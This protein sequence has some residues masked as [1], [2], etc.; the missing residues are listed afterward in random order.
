METIADRLRKIQGEIAVAAERCG[1]QAKDVTLIA[2]SKTHPAEAIREAWDEG[3]RIFGESR[4]QEALAK[5]PDLPQAI[6]WHFIGHIQS[7]KIRKALPHFVL[8]H[9]IDSA[10]CAL[11]MDRI[12]C[13][14]GL[15][16]RILL[17]VNVAGEATKF[18]FDREAL[19]QNMDSLLALRSVDIEGLMAIPP[20]VEKPEDARKYFVSLRELRDELVSTTGTSLPALSMGMSDDFSVAIEEGATLVR[21][22]TSIF[23]RRPKPVVG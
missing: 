17:E 7:N 15:R 12:A 16:A 4:V 19:K 1:R 22:G 3:Q 8:F 10:D 11:A 13:E 6:Q 9:G 21:V 5:I 2:I 18:G 20:A 23:G 14:M